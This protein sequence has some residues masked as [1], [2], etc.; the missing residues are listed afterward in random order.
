MGSLYKLEA[1]IFGVF[2]LIYKQESLSSFFT[3]I[4]AAS[5]ISAVDKIFPE[6]IQKV[7]R[8]ML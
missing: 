8:K 5:F 3:V 4:D 7:D 6:F 2:F 1:M